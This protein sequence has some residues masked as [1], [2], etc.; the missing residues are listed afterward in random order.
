MYFF[1][2]AN[3]CTLRTICK[4]FLLPTVQ[5]SA[6]PDGLLISSLSRYTTIFVPM[7]TLLTVIGEEACEVEDS[8][9]T[10]VNIVKTPKKP[11]QHIP[12]EK[13]QLTEIIKACGSASVCG[14]ALRVW[15][16]SYQCKLN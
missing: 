11:S 4:I 13:K 8:P 6:F 12:N 14:T 5:T 1:R 2:T 15:R 3:V 16:G 9:I 7:A 10:A